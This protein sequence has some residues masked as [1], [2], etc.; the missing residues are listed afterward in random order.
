MIKPALVLAIA[1]AACV[2]DAPPRMPIPSDYEHSASARWLAKP[3]LRSKLL[4]DAE[5]LDSWKIENVDQ[6][7][8][9]LSLTREHAVSGATSLRL[10]CPT[11]GEKFVPTARY[12]GTASARRVVK[13]DC[14]GEARDEVADSKPAHSAGPTFSSGMDDAMDL[15]QPVPPEVA[16]A[17]PTADFTQLMRIV[18]E[19]TGGK[20]A[21]YGEV[22]SFTLPGSQVVGQYSTKYFPNPDF[23]PGL[24][25]FMPDIPVSLRSTD[26]FARHDP[27]MAAILARTAWAS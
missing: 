1:V 15:K 27:A 24:P 18:G 19:P 9:E 23:I 26:Y 6:A 2:T 14:E 11:V 8:G 5:S 10:H 22:K 13:T 20:P 7:K 12:Y 25:S 21:E 17:F 16:A 3:V 4:D